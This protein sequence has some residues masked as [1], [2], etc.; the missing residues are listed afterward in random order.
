MQLAIM[1][2]DKIHSS[3][4][5]RN[6]ITIS[7]FTKYFIGSSFMSNSHCYAIFNTVSFQDF[8]CCF[9][10]V[11]P[12]VKTTKVQYYIWILF[13]SLHANGKSYFIDLLIICY[14]SEFHTHAFDHFDAINNWYF[15]KIFNTAG[16][17]GENR[18]R[19][20]PTI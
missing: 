11:K 20:Y 10:D 15:F 18:I 2:Y 5:Y 8:H 9:H 3:N 7:L 13:H 4:A 14:C 16:S 1:P 12:L 19:S 17:V 6:P